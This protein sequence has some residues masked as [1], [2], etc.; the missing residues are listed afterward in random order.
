[1]KKLISIVLIFTSIL[2]ASPDC[3]S[4]QGRRWLRQ[5]PSGPVE[6]NCNC[7]R[8]YRTTDNSRHG[9][10]CFKCGHTL[11]RKDPENLKITHNK[12]S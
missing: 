12:K 6:C 1:M 3:W 5:E 2:Q 11:V 4:Y 7:D 8:Q 10:R 9:Y